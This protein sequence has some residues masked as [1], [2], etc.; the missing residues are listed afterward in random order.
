MEYTST[1]SERSVSAAQAILKGLAPDGGLY[2]PSRFPAFNISDI[3]KMKDMSYAGVAAMV[4]RPFLPEYGEKELQNYAEEAYSSFEAS[5]VAPLVKLK[6]GKY[7]LELFHG[8]T[9]A[10]KDF[11]LQML[12]R[13]MKGAIEKLDEQYKIMILVATSGDTGK[14]ALEG[15]KDVEGTAITV[16]YPRDGVSGAQRLQMVTQR[17]NNVNVC[18]VTGNFDDAQSAVKRLF[19][20]DEFNERLELE[21]YRTSSANSINWGRLVPQIAYYFFAYS[22]LIKDGL[23]PGEKANFVVPTGNFGNILAAHYARTMGLPVSK[24]IC[25]SNSNNVLTDFFKTGKYDSNREFKKTMSPSMD[26]LISSNLERLLFEVVGRDATAVS[27]LMDKLKYGGVYEIGQE[28]AD[29]LS[30]GFSAGYCSENDTL[31]AIAE[32]YDKNGYVMDPHTA[33]GYHVLEQLD[34]DKNAPSVIVSTASPF[35]FCG[36]VLKAL[37][38]DDSGDE[39]EMAERLAGATGIKLPKKLMEL[40]GAP[41]IFEGVADAE[42]LGIV[43]QEWIKARKDV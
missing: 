2:V 5:E 20:D 18:A 41:I 23:K 19:T 24:L 22:R 1:R 42:G 15:F 4:M 33:V 7:V 6:D 34:Y 38:I 43:V 10:F 25:A 16:F 32:C 29:M 8:P 26:I 12:P 17:G 35:K 37:K 36:S 31:G 27:E 30:H 28:G 40:K 39:F 3:E 13:L 21:G 11:A 14:A 9:L